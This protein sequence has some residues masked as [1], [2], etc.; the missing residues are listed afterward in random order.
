MVLTLV[1]GTFLKCTQVKS[2][3]KKDSAKNI[4]IKSQG[5]VQRVSKILV[6]TLCL[7]LLT[8]L[9]ACTSV[10]HRVGAALNL[11]TDLKL[12]LTAYGDINPDE[13]E[14]SSPVFIRLY[15]LKST[16]AFEKAD[17]IDLYE[18]DED[19]LADALVAKQELK[20]LTPNTKRTDQLVLNKE[21]EYVALFAEFY[22]YKDSKAKVIFPV[23]SSNVV[24]NSIKIEVKGNEIKLL[25]K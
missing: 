14:K 24:R 10:N 23:T 21:T 18:S 22:R 16:A 6:G 11:D 3:V 1:K 4:M 8:F 5:S 19:V 15:E 12:E 13:K 7:S 25:E 2:S 9:S 20:R 17:F